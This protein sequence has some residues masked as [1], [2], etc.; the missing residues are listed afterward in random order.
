MGKLGKMYRGTC[1]LLM[2]VLSVKAQS[3]VQEFF[4]SVD[5]FHAPL[6]GFSL[7]VRPVTLDVAPFT[8]PDP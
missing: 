8:I 1:H 5:T 2:T 6:L 7:G 4:T 3:T